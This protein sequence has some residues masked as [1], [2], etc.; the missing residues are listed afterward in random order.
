MP[1]RAAMPNP[2]ASTVRER[3]V[4]DHVY[5]R[6]VLDWLEHAGDDES[7]AVLLD[8][9]GGYLPDH[10]AS[11]EKPGGLFAVVVRDAPRLARRAKL[12]KDQHGQMLTMLKGLRRDCPHDLVPPCADFRRRVDELVAMLRD[13]EAEETLMLA[14][15]VGAELEEGP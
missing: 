12:L 4:A 5:L 10:F 14:D 15:A 9:L 6:K 8:E 2:V 11:E 7:I 13:H 3:V 1:V